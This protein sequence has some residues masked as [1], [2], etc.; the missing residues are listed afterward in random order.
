[1]AAPCLRPQRHVIGQSDFERLHGHGGFAITR[2]A[3]EAVPGSSRSLY[4]PTTGRPLT[5]QRAVVA[6]YTTT[7]AP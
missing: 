5:D 7:F 1:M 3:S 4:P 6:K 2:A